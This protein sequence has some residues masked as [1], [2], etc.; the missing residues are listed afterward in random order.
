MREQRLGVDRAARLLGAKEAP[1]LSMAR[2]KFLALNLEYSI[3]KAK[4]V[5]GYRPPLSFQEGM[6]EAVRWYQTC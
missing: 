6:A 5:L 4:R 3:A 1:R 2:Y